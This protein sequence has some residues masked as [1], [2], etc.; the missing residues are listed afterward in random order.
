MQRIFTRGEKIIEGF[1]N[2][3]FLIYHDDE[4]SR[5]EDNENDIK[6]NNGLIDYEKLERLINLKR[7]SINDN[8]FREYF[9]YQDPDS[10]LKDLNSTRNTERND[11]PSSLNYKCID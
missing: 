3:I 2:K 10:M 6:D 8:L 11:I 5:F 7:R 4:D 9:E 1:K